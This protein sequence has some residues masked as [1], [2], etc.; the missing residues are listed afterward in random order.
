ML[1]I[2]Q[3]SKVLWMPELDELHSEIDNI[4]SSKRKL[5]ALSNTHSFD[6][7]FTK[8]RKNSI[9]HQ[10]SNT[11]TKTSRANNINTKEITEPSSDEEINSHGS[12]TETEAGEEYEEDEDFHEKINVPTRRKKSRK[13]SDLDN[14]TPTSPSKGKQRNLKN[15]TMSDDFDS[16]SESETEALRFENSPSFAE[17]SMKPLELEFIDGDEDALLQI[18]LDSQSNGFT[19]L[20]FADCMVLEVLDIPNLTRFISER[21][22]DSENSVILRS[23]CL[24]LATELK[25]WLKRVIQAAVSIANE[26]TMMKTKIAGMSFKERFCKK[27]SLEMIM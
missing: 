14:E 7:N 1:T 11:A 16:E 15:S 6:D 22:P 23:A 2:R 13:I 25:K 19:E 8:K 21:Q 27:T 5:S 18:L 3:N 24:A 20:S 12:E 9:S 26:N 4:E 10:N 17:S